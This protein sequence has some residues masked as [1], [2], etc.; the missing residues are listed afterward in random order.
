[1]SQVRKKKNLTK[2]QRT[3]PEWVDGL[4]YCCRS[5]HPCIPARHWPGWSRRERPK[6]AAWTSRTAL[7]FSPLCSKQKKSWSS[8]CGWCPWLPHSAEWRPMRLFAQKRPRSSSADGNERERQDTAETSPNHSVAAY[9]WTL[10]PVTLLQPANEQR[11]KRT[12]SFL[13][14]ITTSSNQELLYHT[15]KQWWERNFVCVVITLRYFGCDGFDFNKTAE[16]L[17]VYYLLNVLAWQSNSSQDYW[18]EQISVRLEVCFI[19]FPFFVFFFFY[20]FVIH[21]HG[22]ILQIQTFL[23]F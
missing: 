14:P 7:K 16:H 4:Q 21:V 13:H 10:K 1:M 6:T 17:Q 2:E 3:P 5:H 20:T 9:H 15:R 23:K 8:C 22:K 18:G 19:T 11:G 12:S